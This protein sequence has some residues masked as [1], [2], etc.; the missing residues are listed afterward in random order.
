LYVSFGRSMPNDREGGSSTCADVGGYEAARWIGFHPLLVEGRSYGHAIPAA[1]GAPQIVDWLLFRDGVFPKAAASSGGLQSE[2]GLYDL[3]EHRYAL[4]NSSTPVAVLAG[5][6]TAS[7]GEYAT[8]ALRQNPRVRVFGGATRGATT[9]MSGFELED[10]SL[11]LIAAA[12][13]VDP[14]GHVFAAVTRAP[15][16][17]GSLLASGDCVA[18]PLQPDVAVAMPAPLTAAAMGRMTPEQIIA[19]RDADPILDAA[20][21][22]L[23]EQPSE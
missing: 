14:C 4:Q 19:Y 23:C 13:M 5:S 10:G 21:A 2:S 15:W 18:E 9:A 11:L 17:A 12:Y 22:W 16:A 6:G 1:D 8:L 3:G 7:A 20:L